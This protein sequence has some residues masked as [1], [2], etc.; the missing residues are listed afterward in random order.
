MEISSY[1][2]FL[3]YFYFFY[4]ITIYLL[5]LWGKWCGGIS[6]EIQHFKKSRNL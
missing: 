5:V 2:K 1:G 6:K 3:V 4:L